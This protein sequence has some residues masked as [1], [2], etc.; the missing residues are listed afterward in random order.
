MKLKFLL[1]IENLIVDIDKTFK[2]TGKIK[3]TTGLPTQNDAV[4]TT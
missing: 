4:K 3:Q 2:K 1:Y